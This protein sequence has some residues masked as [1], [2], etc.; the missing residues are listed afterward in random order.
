MWAFDSLLGH[1]F[2]YIEDMPTAVYYTWDSLG[3]P[4]TPAQPVREIVA[5]LKAHYPDATFSWYADEAHYAANFPE[6]HTPY[7]Y[8]GWPEPCP[9]WW[10]CATDV[11]HR[12]DLGVDCQAI[13]DH[14]ITAAR[15][16]ETPWL[17]YL[18]WQA[19]IYDVRY[20]WEPRGNSGHF[21]HIHASTRTDHLNTGLGSWNPIPGITTGDG[22]MLYL[23]NAPND[24]ALWLS[25]GIIR[26]GVSTQAEAQGW[27]DQGA[28]RYENVDLDWYGVPV[29]VLLS[30]NVDAAAVAAALLADP[31]FKAEL[32][33]AAFEGSQRAEDE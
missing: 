18:I 22:D 27:L 32:R 13:F 4:L 11:M 21:D 30:A 1:C 14:W 6:D 17:K 31:A 25:N 8:T 5:A 7:S 20:D 9:Q 26:R 2:R 16:G 19:R 3:R 29:D 28:V 23:V 24:F 33:Q 10:V 15:A 12:P